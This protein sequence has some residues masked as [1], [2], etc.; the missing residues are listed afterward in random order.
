ME[1]TFTALPLAIVYFSTAGLNIN[2]N[3]LN[4]RVHV[5]LQSSSCGFVTY[6]ILICHHIH[7]DLLLSLCLFVTSGIQI[8]HDIH[9]DLL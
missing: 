9:L 5:Y 3:S 1:A 8:C 6:V 2:G 4:V 7:A